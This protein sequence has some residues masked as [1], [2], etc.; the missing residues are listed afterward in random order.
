MSALTDLLSPDAVAVDVEAADWRAAVA[1]AGALLEATGVATAEYTA[2]MIESVVEKGPYIVIAPGFAFAH[3][4]PSPAVLRT[5]LSWVRLARPVEFGHQRNDPVDLVVA[6]AATDAKA[7]TV[8]MAEL[9]KVIGDR[10]RSAALAA[11]ATPA[12]ILAILRGDRAP[13]T[14]ASPEPAAHEPAAAEP[15]RRTANKILTVCGNGL[16]TSLFL[17]NTLEKVLGDWGWSS[18]ITV[19]A[20]DT[21]SAKGKAKE[22]DLILTSGEIAKALG[23]LGVPMTVIENFTSTA[24]ID[25][26]LRANYD[27]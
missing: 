3:A 9:A 26:A 6:L 4:R 16:G 14:A 13:D 5:G 15:A 2:E 19:E 27:V 24:E 18:Y 12:Q 1:A 10:D 8:A 21:I 25:A 17:K 22:A 7:H 20:T 11:A 23:D